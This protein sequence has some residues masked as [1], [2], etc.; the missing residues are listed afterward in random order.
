MSCQS[1]ITS[2]YYSAISQECD[3]QGTTRAACSV[4]YNAGSM[5]ST[6]STAV[7]IA[8]IPYGGY[9]E[10]RITTTSTGAAAT[11]GASVATSTASSTGTSSSS[12]SGSSSGS[13]SATASSATG[14][15]ATTSAQTSES[16]N[17]AMP[18]VTGHAHWAVGGAAA[19]LALAAV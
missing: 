15:A 8:T 1:L 9:Q 13:G 3:L 12:S 17:A 5:T 19:A 4:S 14:T 10:V 2:S 6:F 11:T 16:T 7:D 18:A